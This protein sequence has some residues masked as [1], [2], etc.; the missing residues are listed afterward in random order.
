MSLWITL[1]LV[2]TWIGICVVVLAL[3]VIAA[4]AD[5]CEGDDERSS[6]TQ[7]RAEQPATCSPRLRSAR[8]NRM[9]AEAS[10]HREKDPSG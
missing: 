3:C 7:A 2:A 10:Q 4:R 5:R 1:A 9:L 6:S 8:R